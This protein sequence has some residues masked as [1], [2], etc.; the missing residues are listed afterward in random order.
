MDLDSKKQLLRKRLDS[1]RTQEVIHDDERQEQQQEEIP[2]IK[3]WKDSEEIA[4]I[5]FQ[6]NKDR[7]KWQKGAEHQKRIRKIKIKNLSPE[8]I[9]K[10]IGKHKLIRKS[11]NLWKCRKPGMKIRGRTTESN[12]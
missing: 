6:T 12:C 1:Q 7:P 3:T 5:L 11:R 4:E 8:E 2:Q 10:T 9:Q